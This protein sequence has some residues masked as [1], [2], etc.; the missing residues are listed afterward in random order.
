[1]DGQTTEFDVDSTMKTQDDILKE[2]LTRTPKVSSQFVSAPA[3]VPKEK[4][5]KDTKQ[6]S[7]KSS[8]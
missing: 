5:A 3:Y 7:A 1:V 2:I 4:K 8:A 6:Q